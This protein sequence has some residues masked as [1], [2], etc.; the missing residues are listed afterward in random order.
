MPKIESFE[1]YLQR[2][3]L[4]WKHE[5]EANRRKRK[6]KDAKMVRQRTKFIQLIA[7]D[8]K[9]LRLSEVERWKKKDWQKKK[10]NSRFSFFRLKFETERSIRKK[11]QIKNIHD[12]AQT[13]V[14]DGNP[15]I[16]WQKMEQTLQ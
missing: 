15:T 8:G 1:D 10:Q 7:V 14:A 9:K 6:L 3:L 5:T 16:H 13:R 11:V 12:I 2:Q 4:I